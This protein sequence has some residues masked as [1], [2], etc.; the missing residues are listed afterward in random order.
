MIKAVRNFD[1]LASSEGRHD[2]LDIVEAAFASLDTKSILRKS[3]T[4]TD[5]VMTVMGE[6]FDLY[7][8]N[9]I[10]ILGFG[11]V[12]CK[13]AR[14]LEEILE[15]KVN[16]GAV[17][18]IKEVVCNTIDTYAGTH[19]LPSRLNLTATQHIEEIAHKA[20]KDDLV[21]VIVSGGG[22][23]LLCSSL[24]ECDQG[25]RLYNAFLRSGG[26]ID[27]LNTVRRHI[28][29]L[30]GGGLAK[31]LYPATVVGLVFSDVPGGN[32]ESI[33]SGPT[34]QSSTMISD[35]EEIIERYGLGEFNLIEKETD[36]KYFARVKNILVAS[37]LTAL[38]A[39]EE[40]AREKGYRAS[41]VSANVY[42]TPEE[43]RQMLLNEAVNQPAVC[44][45]GE[46]KMIVSPHATGKGGR[47]THLGMCMVDVL[48]EDQ[49]FVSF[50]SDG[51][52]NT[53][54]A[55]AIV[56]K[57]T[58]DK[59]RAQ[60]LDIAAYR[61]NFDSYTFLKETGDLMFTSPL[62]SNVADLSL[63]LSPENKNSSVL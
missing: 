2:A 19:P 11:K 60:G 10:Y 16:E 40:A 50:A 13:A 21:L 20:K 34:V 58:L 9:H 27:E 4:V 5:G 15:G 3:I 8:F 45:G 54:A 28:S 30:K 33:A 24:E 1:Q 39:M 25:Q 52:D 7:S 59:A 36:E 22:S 38:K 61:N 29:R 12:S 14:V 49:V 47:N 32:M 18:G 63:L 42:A 31:V 35:A 46:T 62:E 44:M 57:N 23:A 6:Q 53:D 51:K 41:I 48:R 56:D 26:T 55:G 17:V 37:N 43:T